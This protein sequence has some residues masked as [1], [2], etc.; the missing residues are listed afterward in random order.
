M[1]LEQ[2]LQQA[3]TN[4]ELHAAQR[5]RCEYQAHLEEAL[6]TGTT[7]AAFVENLGSAKTANTG[8][9]RA[10]LTL[11]DVAILDSHKGPMHPRWL[12]LYGAYSCFSAL[13]AFIISPIRGV[14]VVAL[15]LAGLG[16]WFWLRAAHRRGALSVRQAGQLCWDAFT[17]LTGI[18]AAL[19]FGQVWWLLCSFTVL[20][21]VGIPRW[22]KLKLDHDSTAGESTA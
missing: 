19:A 5:I 14:I 2:W 4:I 22:R 10:H 16:L 3:T 17:A 15:L 11:S 7:E 1:T 13:V 20:T 18:C 8:F 21:G 6:T 12:W 9:M